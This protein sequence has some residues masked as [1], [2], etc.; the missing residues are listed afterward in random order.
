MC[1][2]LD[3]LDLVFPIETLI[4]DIIRVL[5]KYSSEGGAVLF[6][7]TQRSI[8]HFVYL[9]QSADILEVEIGKERVL[10]DVR[11]LVHKYAQDIF[12]NKRSA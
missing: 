6:A 5:C 7:G 9:M 3:I 11:L 2:V 12:C 10:Q 1:L 4:K 8:A